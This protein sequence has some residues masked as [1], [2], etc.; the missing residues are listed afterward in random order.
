M[1]PVHLY[2]P[3]AV[4]GVNHITFSKIAGCMNEKIFT[5]NPNGMAIF[6]CFIFHVAG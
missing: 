4:V 1:L 3:L 6:I 5:D 2:E